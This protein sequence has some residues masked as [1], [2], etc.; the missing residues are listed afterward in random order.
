MISCPK[1]VLKKGNVFYIE[2]SAGGNRIIA[3]KLNV[4]NVRF[5][6]LITWRSRLTKHMTGA[7]NTFF[8]IKIN[9]NTEQHNIQWTDLNS[10]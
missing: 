6:D 2:T 4:S 7:I 8:G 10:N 1:V 5:I 9:G 3:A